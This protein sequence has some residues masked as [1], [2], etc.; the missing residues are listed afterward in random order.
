MSTVN[1]AI[2]VGNLAD[3]PTLN[4]SR[5]GRPVSNMRLA[6]NRNYKDA[7][8][9]PQKTTE[10]HRV[11]VWGKNAEHC[12][13]YLD[14]GRKIYVEGRLETKQWEDG[15]GNTRYTTEVVADTVRFLG[16]PNRD[17][18]TVEDDE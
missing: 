9:N 7:N 12:H 6:T 2:L 17:Y 1:K 14:K 10:W 3:K 8:G 5:A 16:R 4:H 18:E 15:E 11:V 13:R